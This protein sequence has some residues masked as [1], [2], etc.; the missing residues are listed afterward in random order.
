MSSQSDAAGGSEEGGLTRVRA[1]RDGHAN[2]GAAY[3]ALGR[4]PELG[5]VVGGLRA[6]GYE[7]FASRLPGGGVA[8]SYLA[9]T[10][11]VG[12]SDLA[13]ATTAAKVVVVAAL[14]MSPLV[15][16]FAYTTFQSRLGAADDE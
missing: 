16:S 12:G 10:V 8:V 14:G 15:T 4:R 1:L 5:T 13:P 7:R 6:R 11:A 9:P 2:A 3:R